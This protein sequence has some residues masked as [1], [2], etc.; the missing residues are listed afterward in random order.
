MGKLP[1]VPTDFAARNAADL[2]QS[3]GAGEW[4]SA[5]RAASRNLSPTDLRVVDSIDQ[6]QDWVVD[7]SVQEIA[8]KAN[9]SP[10]TVVR[11]CQR[12][13]FPG[14]QAVKFVLARDMARRESGSQF[15]ATLDHLSSP[16]DVLATVLSYNA[17]TVLD[18]THTL[19]PATFAAVV[20]KLTTASN[21]LVVGNGTSKAP[22]SD[23][24]YRCASLGVRTQHTGDSLEQHLLAAQLTENDLCIA[25]SHSGRTRET[26]LAAEAAKHAGAAVCALTS[27][28]ESPLTE[29][30]E[31]ILLAGEPEYG[32][33]DEA[34]VGRVAHMAVI[35]ALFV[36]LSLAVPEALERSRTITAAVRVGHTD[37][38]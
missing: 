19:A 7:A 3:S 15:P 38:T 17:R 32:F 13:G 8:A 10:S 14:I 12:L 31:F 33:R 16:K 26:L 35:D 2:G 37:T 36:A 23:A 18:V 34:M 25:I 5:V 24:A 27:F 11:V 29:I 6:H 1:S 9:V 30:A 4:Q 20:E 28:R 21:V 22:A